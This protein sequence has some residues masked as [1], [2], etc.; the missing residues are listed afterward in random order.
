[1]YKWIL[2]YFQSMSNVVVPE[3]NFTRLNTIS[4][5]R[6]YSRRNSVLN[7]QEDFTLFNTIFIT[8]IKYKKWNKPPIP[9][10]W[11]A[12]W[13]LRMNE[14]TAVNNYYQSFRHTLAS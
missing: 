8:R 9:Y 4:W 1:M 12:Q 10:W 13:H 3:K 11:F 2:M 14:Q 5:K 7:K 6:I